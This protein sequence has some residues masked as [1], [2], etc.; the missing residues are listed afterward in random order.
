MLL[1]NQIAGICN[2]Q[3][4]KKKFFVHFIFCHTQEYIINKETE[5]A[6]FDL[7]QLPDI[8]GF[9]GQIYGQNNVSISNGLIFKKS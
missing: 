1:N 6:Y 9:I 4:H 8:A 3:Y 5:T 7:E 2:Q